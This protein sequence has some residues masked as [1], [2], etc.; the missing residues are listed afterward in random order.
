M[1]RLWDKG[2][3]LDPLILDYTTG[4]DPTTDV[5]LVIEDC[6]GS[7]AHARMLVEQG[8]LDEADRA[9]IAKGLR[10]ILAE[11][12]AGKFSIPRELEDVHTAIESRLGEAGK[13][14]HLGRSRN[15]QVLT[16]LR[17]HAKRKLL[18]LEDAALE[19]ARALLELARE[20]ER[21]PL[22]GYTHLRRAMPSSVGLWAAGFAE[23]VSDD[24]DL[25]A[26]ARVAQDR[27]PLGSAAG[28]GVPLPLDRA[29]SAALMAFERV[30]T[31]VQA[32][33]SSRGKNEAHALFAC[34]QLGHSLAKLSWD[35]ELYSAPEFNFVKL[36]PDVAT[37][38]S[39][40]PQKRNPDVV[41]LT[42]ANAA[43]LE[44]YLQRILSVA[45][46]LPSSYHRDYQVTKE[47]LVR[48]LDLAIQM[49]R[50]MFRVVMGLEFD[51]AA[52]DAAV[53]DETFCAHRAFELT[54]Q[55]VPFR[56]AYKRTADE[57]ARGEVRRPRDLGPVLAAY[58][59]AG[60]AGD[61][62]LDE[63]KARLERQGEATRRARSHFEARLS[64]LEQDRA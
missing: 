29:R 27:S 48:G 6:W 32:V 26:Q 59:V 38:S 39:I 15:D 63:A 4:D 24:L 1:A 47:P 54:L 60:A 20:H 25:L 58:K 12:R 34:V 33:Q 13:R 18:E 53:T 57:H 64:D 21:T 61:L 41:E 17:L 8:L 62:R 46:R 52:C 16:C 45:G 40:M 3:K 55:G 43:V 42:R 22:P 36:G 28:F 5:S 2:E 23:L 19:L 37:G 56:D 35:L 51:A 10:A 9:A 11:A 30:Q 7:L 50:A 14:V 49:T 44:S 31:N